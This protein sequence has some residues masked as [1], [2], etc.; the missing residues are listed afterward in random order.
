MPWW[1]YGLATLLKITCLHLSEHDT[2]MPGKIRLCIFTHCPLPDRIGRFFE[3]FLHRVR[4][5]GMHSDQLQVMLLLVLHYSVLANSIG[6]LPVI[7]KMCTFGMFSDLLQLLMAQNYNCCQDVWRRW[8]SKLGQSCVSTKRD[9][10]NP[11][12]KSCLRHTHLFSGRVSKGDVWRDMW[13]LR[14]VGSF[15]S[16]P[17]YL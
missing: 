8:K 6:I 16:N 15:I 17:F 5:L 10:A 13:G 9:L 14:R 12:M 3:E 11:C 4:V 7:Q 1:P 2:R